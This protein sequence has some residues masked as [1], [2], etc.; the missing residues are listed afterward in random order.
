M[1]FRLLVLRGNT[2]AYSGEDRQLNGDAG[3]LNAIQKDVQ[4]LVQAIG[5][6]EQDMKERREKN[7]K[8]WAGYYERH[9]E[10]ERKIHHIDDAGCSLHSS[11]HCQVKELD[12]R[13]QKRLLVGFS[14]IG[15]LI[16][17]M[18][19]WLHYGGKG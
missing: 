1:I 11:M 3:Q 5:K 2:V 19:L 16:T 13:N 17:L 9:R 15:L 12:R 8:R 18:S 6:I 10:I 4:Y 7:D 14:A